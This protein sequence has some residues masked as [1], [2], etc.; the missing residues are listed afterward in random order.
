MQIFKKSPHI[1]FF[2]SECGRACQM[3]GDVLWSVKNAGI[4]FV[5]I[6]RICHQVL[7]LS[8]VSADLSFELDAKMGKTENI[9]CHFEILESLCIVI[10]NY[11]SAFIA[12]RTVKNGTYFYLEN[13]FFLLYRII[14]PDNFGLKYI[15]SGCLYL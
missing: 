4:I 13:N 15:K 3:V 9:M 1:S 10:P 14:F 8:G 7:I 12:L 5:T 6:F 2:K 11:F